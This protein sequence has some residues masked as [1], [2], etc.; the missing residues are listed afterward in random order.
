MD[1]VV[2]TLKAKYSETNMDII[3]FLCMINIIHGYDDV[4]EFLKELLKNEKFHT[5]TA[6]VKNRK[7][8]FEIIKTFNYN[9]Q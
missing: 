7:E 6:R 5:N 1:Y 2:D 8:L 4:N 9:T 3:E